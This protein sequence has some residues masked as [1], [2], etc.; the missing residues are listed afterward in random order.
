HATA[1]VAT[2]PIRR[3]LRTYP[4]QADRV[5]YRIPLSR[6]K[7]CRGGECGEA[8]IP[9]CRVL[10][11][12]G[13]LAPAACRRRARGSLR[14]AIERRQVLGD[15]RAGA[16]DATRIRQ[17]DAGTDAEHQLLSPALGSPARRSARVRL[18]RGARRDSA[19][20]AAVY[21][22]LSCR[23]RSA[24]RTGIGDG[25]AAA[26]NRPGPA[27]ARLVPSLTAPDPYPPDQG[28][29]IHR[30]RTGTHS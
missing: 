29:Q 19:T 3:A 26:D 15:Q 21:R 22:A 12:G 6:P 14:R 20:L 13:G 1:R 30:R 25:R 27:N 23:A 5:L 24:P 17:Q 2:P 16:A 4:M 28:R 9:K 8:S 7:R 10:D 18:R 11:D